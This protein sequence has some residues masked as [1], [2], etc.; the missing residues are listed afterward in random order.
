MG[1]H[2]PTAINE[3]L[4]GHSDLAMS[5]ATRVRRCWSLT[6][7]HRSVA[8]RDELAAK[9]LTDATD[10]VVQVHD[11]DGV[12]IDARVTAMPDDEL[13]ALVVVLA[14]VV[15]DDRPVE[16][17][18]AWT[19]HP[20]RT[21]RTSARPASTQLSADERDEIANAVL[22]FALDVTAGVRTWNAEK[23]ETVLAT[24]NRAVLSALVV[25]LAAMV[26]DDRVLNDLLAWTHHPT[27]KICTACRRRKYVD[28]F[29][30]TRAVPGGRDFACRGCRT[31][32]NEGRIAS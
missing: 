9:M 21:I 2:H 13:Y 22:P 27:R 28:D 18:T 17:L 14:V 7:H 19:H 23:I 20:I 8:D 31:A 3:H 24:L 15:P 11:W 25:V 6:G 29:A 32:E 10:L 4:H 12:A 5:G 30:E 16:A 1:L 26:P